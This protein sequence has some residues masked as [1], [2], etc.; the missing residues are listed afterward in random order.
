MMAL[1][2][3]HPPNQ[4]P[5]SSKQ[6]PALDQIA[7]GARS[8]SEQIPKTGTPPQQHDM[9]EPAFTRPAHNSF[10]SF[11]SFPARETPLGAS[12]LFSHQPA[13]IDPVHPVQHSA[14]FLGSPTPNQLIPKTPTTATTTVLPPFTP[15][16]PSEPKESTLSYSPTVSPILISSTTHPR[17]SPQ[18]LTSPKPPASPSHSNPAVQ[19]HHT[20]SRPIFTHQ[21]TLS[22]HVFGAPNSVFQSS[23]KSPLRYNTPIGPSPYAPPSSPY[24]SLTTPPYKSSISPLQVVASS[25]IHPSPS[26]RLL[27]ISHSPPRVPPPSPHVQTHHEAAH[28]TR[29]PQH[30]TTPLPHHGPHNHYEYTTRHSFVSVQFGGSGLA[31]EASY[32]FAQNLGINS[33]QA[34]LKLQPNL[35]GKQTF[36]GAPQP[37][38]NPSLHPSSHPRPDHPAKAREIIPLIKEVP[39]SGNSPPVTHGLRSTHPIAHSTSH[40][41]TTHPTDPHLTGH[42]LASYQVEPPAGHQYGYSPAPSQ[43]ITHSLPPLHRPHPTKS[44]PYVNRIF[45]L[46]T[47]NPQLVTH[48]S[49]GRNHPEPF[50][51]SSRPPTSP[52]SHTSVPAVVHSLPSTSTSVPPTKHP[53]RHYGYHITPIKAV[54]KKPEKKTESL[55][56]RSTTP[57]PTTRAPPTEKIASEEEQVRHIAVGSETA[58]Q[59]ALQVFRGSDESKRPRRIRLIGPIAVR[60]TGPKTFTLVGQQPVQLERLLLDKE[61]NR[62]GSSVF[63][64]RPSIQFD[65]DTDL[66]ASFP[67]VI[68]LIAISTI[69]VHKLF[70][71]RS[72]SPAT[73]PAPGFGSSRPPGPGSQGLTLENVPAVSGPATNYL[74]GDSL[75]QPTLASSPLPQKTASGGSQW[76]AQIVTPPASANMRPFKTAV[77]ALDMNLGSGW[78]QTALGKKK[79]PALHFDDQ[80]RQRTYVR[81]EEVDT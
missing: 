71:I 62:L 52:T 46:P 49:P 9:I 69:I 15:P 48:P 68:S 6:I 2:S 20:T 73:Q 53:V 39:S 75:P 60:A 17:L 28:G 42:H 16:V 80:G 65:E 61:D 34:P 47:P 63:S 40:S 41:P 77:A 44:L 21:S 14:P 66:S 55:V 72:V 51:S 32:P 35:S 43:A 38:P 30:V 31:N 57:R 5:P 67:Q 45:H 76:A 26:P 59:Q 64:K 33:H 25:H 79:A 50:S 70:Q 1:N 23:T 29:G 37:T 78:K 24:T 18:I 10:P 54:I 4:I 74:R 13:N 12:Q 7:E 8:S 3:G 22:P 19:P 11:A 27:T 81:F 36:L 56:T 58:V